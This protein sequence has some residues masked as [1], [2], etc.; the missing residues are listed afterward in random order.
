MIWI[1]LLLSA[2][3]SSAIGTTVH[4]IRKDRFT[5]YFGFDLG[6]FKLIKDNIE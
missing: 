6:M 3:V 1:P 4:S 2:G 5:P